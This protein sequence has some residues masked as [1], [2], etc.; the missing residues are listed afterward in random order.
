MDGR[1][2]AWV[3]YDVDWPAS[4]AAGQYLYR[5]TG[6]P[7]FAIGTRRVTREDYEREV[8]RRMQ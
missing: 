8:Q 6:G 5:V 2:R 3:E 7:Y 1:M 4:L